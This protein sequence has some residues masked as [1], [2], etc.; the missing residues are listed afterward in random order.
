LYTEYEEELLSG[1][2][3][4]CIEWVEASGDGVLS[5]GLCGVVAREDEWVY[6]GAGEVIAEAYFGAFKGDSGGLLGGFA[7]GDYDNTGNDAA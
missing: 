3:G 4:D 5:E 1:Y 7:V 2:V 6:V